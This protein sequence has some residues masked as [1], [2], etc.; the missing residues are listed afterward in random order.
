MN[1][2][3]VM[4]W[5][6]SKNQEAEEVFR[7]TLGIERRVLGE[8]HP[9]TLKSMGNLGLIH[10]NQGRTE[11]VLSLTAELVRHRRTAAERDDASPRELNDYRWLLLTCQPPER[12]DL[13]DGLGFV[14]K[15]VFCS[16]RSAQRNRC[17]DS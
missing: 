8:E 13:A 5:F 3:G 11:E 16:G 7:S 14:P 2:L 10:R 4:L 15:P 17:A 12:R 6:Q 9:E 1:N